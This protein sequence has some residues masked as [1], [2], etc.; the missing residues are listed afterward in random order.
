MSFY[1]GIYLLLFY[2]ASIILLSFIVILLN[3]QALNYF[4]Y[5]TRQQLSSSSTTAARQQPS[6]SPVS[7]SMAAAPQQLGAGVAVACQQQ[8]VWPFS[9]NFAKF[10]RF[11]VILNL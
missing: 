1:F 7:G 10:F 6:L 2:F 8:H 11:Y 4:F 9:K 3:K 5:Q